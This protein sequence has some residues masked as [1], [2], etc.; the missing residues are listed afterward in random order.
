MSS[1]RKNLG[2]PGEEK[3]PVSE[4]QEKNKALVRRLYELDAR[5]DIE[6]MEKL[7]A[8]DFVD[9]VCFPTKTPDAKAT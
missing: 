1:L 3:V 2:W 4:T 7:L 5:G 9:P 6:A 8:P